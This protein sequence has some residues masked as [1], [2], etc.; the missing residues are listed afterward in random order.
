MGPDMGVTVS[1]RP[2]LRPRPRARARGARAATPRWRDAW[3]RAVGLARWS[4]GPAGVGAVGALGAAPARAHDLRPRRRD[5]AVR[6]GRRRARR[7]GGAVGQRLVPGDRPRRL[8]PTTRGA[9]RSSRSTRCCV[10]RGR[11]GRCGSA[12]RRGRRSCRWRASA[13]RSPPAPAGRARARRDGRAQTVWAAARSSRRRFFFSAVYSESLFLALS[14]GAVLRRADAAAGRGRACSARSAPRPAARACC[15][16][17]RSRSCGSRGRDGRA[18]AR[19]DAAVD[20]ARARPGLAAL[21]R[22]TSR[23]AAATRSRRSR[24]GR[25]GSA[26]SRGRSPAL[27]DGARRRLGRRAPARHGSR[28]ARVLRRGRR[29]P[30]RRRAPQPRAVR[31]PRCAVVATGRRAAPAAAR[32]RRLRVAALAL[33]LSYPVGAA[34]ADVA[35]ALRRRPVPA[36]HVAGALVADAARGSR[37]GR[38]ARRRR[39]AA[40][41]ALQR[42]CS[43]PGTGS[44]E[45]RPARVLL[46]A[47]GTLRRARAARRRALRRRAARAR[48][49]RSTEDDGAPRRCAAEIAYYR[50]HHDEARRPSPALADLRRPLRR[51]PARRAARRPALPVGRRRGRAARRAALPRRTPRCPACSRALRGARRRARRRVATGTSRCTTCSRETRPGAAARRRRHLGRVRARQARPGDLRATPST[52]AGV[53]ARPRPLHVGDTSTSRRRRARGRRGSQPVLVARD[54][55]ARPAPAFGRRA[56]SGRAAA[57]WPAAVPS[58]PGDD[59]RRSRTRIPSRPRAPR[60]ARGSC[61]APAAPGRR[62]RRPSRSSPGFAARALRRARHRRRSPAPSAR[63]STTS[64]PGSTI[65]ATVVQDVAPRSAARS[66]FARMSAR[67]APGR[68]RPAARRASGR[69]S[70]GSSLGWLA[71]SPFTRDL[72]GVARRQPTKDDL[73]EEL[74]ADNS[75]AALL[76]VA[77]LVS[78]VAPVAEEFFFRGY[79]FTA[80]RNWRGVWPAAIVT[81]LVFGAIHAGSA[82]VAFLVPLAFFGFVL[83]LHLREDRLA[84]PVHRAALRQQLDRVRRHPDWTWQIP[85]LFVG[86]LAIIGLVMLAVRQVR[87]PR[88]AAAPRRPGGPRP[89]PAKAYDGLVAVDGIDFEVPRAS[90]SAFSAPTAPARRRR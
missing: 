70:A 37:G 87:S 16:S 52:L 59:V 74:G 71:S 66:L 21:L 45:R 31:V 33:P 54:G 47:L 39:G 84:V 43:R 83:C 49:S 60:A 58:V 38:G 41:A 19:G 10:A 14:V 18:A 40:L 82:P 75:T 79:F 77:F 15:S 27:W 57:S 78:V 73:P 23:S 7:A 5:A 34:A 17:C 32:L 6:P 29:R 80:L 35:A 64:R 20:R 50:A 12:A 86:S 88:P 76:A 42:R 9:R 53:P 48:A 51:G 68:L 56:R 62:G 55:D 8:P 28:D 36:V 65:A 26:T 69:R 2:T 89:R 11:R 81:G 46:D 72:G 61:R 85:L 24:A 67:A 22:A 30:V 1:Q 44:R 3:A 4:C 90:A 25:R 63:T 13:S